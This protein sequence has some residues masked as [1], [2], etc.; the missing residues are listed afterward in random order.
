[1]EKFD[2]VLENAF[3]KAKTVILEESTTAEEAKRYEIVLTE[4]ANSLQKVKDFVK[5]HKGK[6]GAL[7]AAALAGGAYAGARQGAF[8]QGAQEAVKGFE[9]KTVE[10]SKAAVEQAKDL[11]QKL[12]GL[13]GGGK[14]VATKEDVKGTPSEIGTDYDLKTLQA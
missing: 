11:G 10:A 14:K 4:A 2:L 1:M 12:V 8:G 13:F 5:Q 9:Q 6:L 7:A 3:L